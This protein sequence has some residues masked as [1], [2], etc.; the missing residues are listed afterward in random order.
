MKFKNVAIAFDPADHLDVLQGHSYAELDRICVQAIKAAIIDR[1]KEVSS[2]DFK[3]AVADDT[4]LR[5]LCGHWLCHQAAKHGELRLH[6]PAV[7]LHTSPACTAGR[8][9]RRDVGASAVSALG[10]EKQRT[11]GRTTSMRRRADIYFF[12]THRH[13]H[14][15][16]ATWPV[17][18]GRPPPRARCGAPPSHG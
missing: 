13:Q 18:R 8:A 10:G 16:T 15:T 3:D 17:K 2:S 11:S 7:V 5:V 9:A 1:R 12:T 6:D 4:R 14:Q